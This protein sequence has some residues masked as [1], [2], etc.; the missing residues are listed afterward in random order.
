[1]LGELQGG[2]FLDPLPNPNRRRDE[3]NRFSEGQGT[4]EPARR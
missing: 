2:K 1:M 4:H 3:D